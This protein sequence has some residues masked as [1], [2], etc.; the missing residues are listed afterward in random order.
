MTAADYAHLLIEN[1]TITAYNR[2]IPFLEKEIALRVANAKATNTATVANEAFNASMIKSPIGI[3]ILAF[4][5][6]I[7]ILAAVE[8]HYKKVAE[9]AKETA[10]E[11]KKVAD[12]LNTETQAHNQ[13][14]EEFE[15]LNQQ[16][17]D[18]LIEK[19]AL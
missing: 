8:N 6:L 18:G 1:K 13:L 19:E 9:A 17:K 4:T 14:V 10:E 5:A 12:E 16:Y 2:D 15:E 3:A 7:G 11:S